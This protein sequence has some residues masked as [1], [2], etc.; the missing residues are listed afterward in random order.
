MEFQQSK[1]YANI[2]A[3]YEREL[4]LSTQYRIFSDKARTDGY[5]QISNIFDT[6]SRNEFEHSRIFLRQLNNGVLPNTQENLTF[7]SST[8][9]SLG[10]EYR[11]YATVAREEGYDDLAALFNGIANIEL[12][13]DLLFQSLSA[14]VARGTVFCKPTESLWIC[15]QCGNIMSGECAPEIC[16][17]CLFPQG[18]Y[19]EYTN[20]SL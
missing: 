17:V 14:E 20:T 4:M 3:S 11:T 2:Q 10:D 16:P 12:N 9:I 7:S 13:H 8:E 6:T 18:Y 15:I 1:T 19:Q 5:I